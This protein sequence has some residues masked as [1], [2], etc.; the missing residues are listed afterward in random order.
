MKL[1]LILASLFPLLAEAST[2]QIR[3]ENLLRE[4]VASEAA[5]NKKDL[6]AFELSEPEPVKNEVCIGR[7]GALTCW[8]I[9]LP[10]VFTYSSSP[11][12]VDDG[13]LSG[14][15]FTARVVMSQYSCTITRL[16]IFWGR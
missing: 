10:D 6:P 11:F 12:M 8:D 4:V 9:P 15:G 16:D 2:A 7:A 5:R 14:S 1:L 13:Y 3:C